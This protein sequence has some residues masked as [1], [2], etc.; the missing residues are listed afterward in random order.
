MTLL[1]VVTFVI[2]NR[3]PSTIVDVAVS[4]NMVAIALSNN[5]LMRLELSNPSEI[6]RK[7]ARMHLYSIWDQ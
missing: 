4:N 5:E 7:Y 3:P 6:D 2:I 1:I